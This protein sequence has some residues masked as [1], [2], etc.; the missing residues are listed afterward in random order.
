M[1]V[2]SVLSIARLKRVK[3]LL[4]G[5]AVFVSAAKIKARI[6]HSIATH[7][8]NV[9]R[10]D[11]SCHCQNQGKKKALR[12]SPFQDDVVAGE[13]L[14]AVHVYHAKAGGGRIHLLFPEFGHVVEKF[15]ALG[16]VKKVA[17]P[18]PQS[19]AKFESLIMRWA[20]SMTNYK[21]AVYNPSFAVL[22]NNVQRALVPLGDHGII[23]S[24]S[25]LSDQN[26]DATWLLIFW[27]YLI[28]FDDEVH[29]FTSSLV[30]LSTDRLKDHFV[31][32]LR[33]IMDQ[34]LI[35]CTTRCALGVHLEN[36]IIYADT[37]VGA[38]EACVVDTESSSV[39]YV[40][41]QLLVIES[42]LILRIWAIMGKKLWIL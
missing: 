9:G 10:S 8:Q 30:G 42:I 12:R 14:V 40:T 38:Y 20:G 5:R 1:T 36:V 2:C 31:L 37:T 19:G 18:S 13:I 25:D 4:W 23:L 34:I 17:S 27:D 15:G 28:T 6:D 21:L 24:S 33:K 39:L 11:P 26:A 35:L 29:P 32:V 41:I 7:H 3:R 16:R 22:I